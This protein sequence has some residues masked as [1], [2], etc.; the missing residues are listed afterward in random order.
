MR[1]RMIVN[2][3]KKAKNGPD[4]CLYNTCRHLT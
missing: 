1:E 2:N 3:L 4:D